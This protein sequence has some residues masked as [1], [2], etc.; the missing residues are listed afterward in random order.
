MKT[1]IQDFLQKVG[2]GSKVYRQ[3]VVSMYY[4]MLNSKSFESFSS[5]KMELEAGHRTDGALSDPQV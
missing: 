5:L 2:K 4:E 1:N 3:P